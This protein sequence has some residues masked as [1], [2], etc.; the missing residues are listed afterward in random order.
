MAQRRLAP[1]VTLVPILLYHAVSTDT[2][3]L[4]RDYAVSERTFAAHMD[5]VA[6]SGLTPLTVS[7][8]LEAQRR[9]DD[10][11]LDTAVLITFDDG[12]ADVLS[13]AAPV[14]LDRKLTA[15]LFIATGLLRGGA[16]PSVAPELAPWML[17]W[18]QVPELPASGIEVGAHSHTHPHM[19]T[20]STK[21]LRSEI[22]RSKS[23]LEDAL[24]APIATF[25]YPHGYT[26]RRVKRELRAAGFRGACGVKDAFS[27][28]GD[29]PFALARLMLRATTP[30]S[31][32]AKWLERR[33]APPPPR[34][35][36]VRTTGWRV[37]RRAKALLSRTPGADDGWRF[38]G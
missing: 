33:G 9:R 6:D 36:H 37:Y 2:A 17:D 34:R 10:E 26:S 32:V 11:L 21:Q 5:L 27:A 15:T 22:G 29:D 18:K 13:V 24:E 31:D 25:A 28:T 14:L 20:L 19:D 35:E 8:L 4:G 1:P 38:S 3:P 12:F 30:G 16:R 23:L 7:Q